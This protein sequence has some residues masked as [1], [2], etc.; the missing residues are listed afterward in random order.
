M[1]QF[2]QGTFNAV[3]APRRILFR[4]APHR[5]NDLVRDRRASRG[6]PVLAVVPVCDDEFLMPAQ[7]CFRSHDGSKLV[8][9]LAAENLA[10]DGEPPLPGIVV[11]KSP[12]GKVESEAHGRF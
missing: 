8:E 6:F 5:L 12:E 7:D 9:H 3:M 10:F 1:S 2:R 4:H 11:E